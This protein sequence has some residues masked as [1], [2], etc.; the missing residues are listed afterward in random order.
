MDEFDELENFEVMQEARALA[1]LIYE[2]TDCGG[3]TMDFVLRDEI[4]KAA[5]AI[6]T[7]IARGYGGDTAAYIQR[8]LRKSRSTCYVLVTLL[9]IGRDL[10]YVSNEELAKLSRPVKTII[11]MLDDL[12]YDFARRRRHR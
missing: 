10:G 4:R 3:W 2:H 8:Y 9:T 11:Q 12:L 5:I 7:E 6:S 1:V